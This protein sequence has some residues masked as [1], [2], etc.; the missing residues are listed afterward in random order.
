MASDMGSGDEGEES[1]AMDMGSSMH[2]SEPMMGTQE[3]A[4]PTEEPKP[5]GRRTQLKIVREHLESLKNDVWGVRKL[6]ETNQKRLEAQ[7]AKVRSEL[8]AHSKSKDV[9]KELKRHDAATKKLQ[10]ELSAVRKDLAATRKDIAREAVKSRA[11]EEAAISK[12]AAKVKSKS[13]A[14]PKRS[15]KK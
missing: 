8:K 7:V 12:I 15:K 9:I 1:H 3:G 11:R 6:H 10:R 5:E 13:K 2:T 14:A 4:Q